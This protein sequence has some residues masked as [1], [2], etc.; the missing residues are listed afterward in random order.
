MFTDHETLQFIQTLTILLLQTLTILLLQTL[1]ILLLQTLTFFTTMNPYHLSIVNPELSHYYKPSP[2]SL[3][4]TLTSLTTITSHLYNCAYSWIW[5]LC[6][7]AWHSH[8]ISTSWYT[9]CLPVYTLTKCMLADIL[10]TSWS[11]CTLTNIY[12]TIYTLLFLFQHV[13]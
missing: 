9:R 6:S 7:A 13:H 1:T 3:L 12:I 11:L 10:T 4:W 2:L 5:N 8:W